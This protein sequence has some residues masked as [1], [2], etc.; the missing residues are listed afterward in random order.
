MDD[1][2]VNGGK[3]KNKLIFRSLNKFKISVFT[4]PII[5]SKIYSMYV[6]CTYLLPT[7][8]KS[9]F[10]NELPQLILQKMHNKGPPFVIHMH[11]LSKYLLL[12]KIDVNTILH[13]T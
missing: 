6:P 2:A 1:A 8:F 10:E 13:H 5:D 7:I 9:M 3:N 12:I 11:M 4:Q